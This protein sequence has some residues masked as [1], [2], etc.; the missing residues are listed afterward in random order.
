[1]KYF[2]NFGKVNFQ[3]G[4]IFKHHISTLVFLSDDVHNVDN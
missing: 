2:V 4:H 1:M 3:G